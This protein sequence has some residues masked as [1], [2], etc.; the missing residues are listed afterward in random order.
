MTLVEFVDAGNNPEPWKGPDDPRPDVASR[1]TLDA[2]FVPPSGVANL[3]LETET[4][5]L[6]KNADQVMIFSAGAQVDVEGFDEVTDTGTRWKI[7]VLR[8]LKPGDVNILAYAG[9]SR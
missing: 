2:V 8:V 4:E 1:L 9:V 7:D 6:F 5:D 3:G